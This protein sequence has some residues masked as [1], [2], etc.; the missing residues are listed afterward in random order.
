MQLTRTSD[1][2]RR[3]ILFN[4]ARGVAP[5][6]APMGT[7]YFSLIFIRGGCGSITIRL[8][9][10]GEASVPL[11]APMAVCLR[12][13][14]AVVQAPQGGEVYN[15]V[16]SPT[17]I[18]VNMKSHLL[19][20][21]VY[22]HLAAVHHLFTLA[23][24]METNPELKCLAMN[25]EQMA[26]YFVFC[27]SAVRAMEEENPDNC[28]SCRIRACLMDILTGLETQYAHRR[29]A[30]EDNS[31]TF[32]T[33]RDMVLYMYA[34]LSHPCRIEQICRRFGVNRNKLQQIFRTYSGLTYYDFMK[35]ARLERAQ[36]YLAFTGLRLSEIAC[37][38][39][40]STEQHFYR[41][42]RR[43]S[44]KSP[45]DFRKTAV[46]GRKAAFACFNRSAQADPGCFPLDT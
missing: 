30:M 32:T 13:D 24:F 40:F 11:H 44:G 6:S 28:W 43:E 42:F 7:G 14:E 29:R 27:D 9:D 31:V 25:D 20:E 8:R 15:L 41:F 37:R 35:K 2:L 3:T 34:D 10:G 38:L 17:F 22:I 19:A 1:K 45:Y 46:T 33:Y 5:F 26:A 12:D 39:G 4:A 36:S 23:P 21:E 16:F 18:N